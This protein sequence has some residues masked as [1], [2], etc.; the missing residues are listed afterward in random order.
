M[1]GA[2]MSVESSGLPTKVV[3]AESSA[4]GSAMTT[5]MVVVALAIRNAL[6]RPSR[7]TGSLKTFRTW[8][9]VNE[10]SSVTNALA[11]PSQMG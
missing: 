7:K 6:I 11:T 9:S 5:A 2:R 1:S 8:K 10:P 4:S 3:R